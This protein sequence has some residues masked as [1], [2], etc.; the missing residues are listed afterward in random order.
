M[1]ISV[2]IADDE[3]IARAGL[4]DML[5]EYEW[6]SVVGEAASGPAAVEA[7]NALR[8]EIVFL[9]IQMPEIGRAHV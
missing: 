9:D 4:R 5:A 7:I 3:P 1:T 6:V 8:P 2:V